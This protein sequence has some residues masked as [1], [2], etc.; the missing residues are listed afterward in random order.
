MKRVT[1]I[2]ILIALLI[3]GYILVTGN[4]DSSEVSNIPTTGRSN[5]SSQTQA[6]PEYENYIEYS[7]EALANAQAQ[8][9]GRTLLF[10]RADWCPTCKAAEKDILK[11]SSQLPEDL[12]I[13][14]TD[15]DTEIALKEKYD[16]VYQ[17]TFVQVDSNGNEITKWS[18]GGVK[19]ILQNLEEV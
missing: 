5:E 8:E 11:N 19:T 1:P 17:H 13:L 9:N 15:Y 14:R 10:F 4:S 16:I 3:G 18:G 12:I 7:E 2:L 6:L